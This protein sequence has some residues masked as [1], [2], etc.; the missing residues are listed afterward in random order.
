MS[1]EALARVGLAI[2]PRIP[3]KKLSVAQQLVE[4][5]KALSVDARSSS[6][7]SRPRP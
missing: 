1:R 4:I 3:I 5:A 6:W 2:D 7:T